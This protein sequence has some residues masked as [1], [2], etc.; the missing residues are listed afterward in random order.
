MTT[1]LSLLE[2]AIGYQFKD[3]NLLK[4]ALTHRSK[5]KN[6]NERFEFLGDALLETVISAQL[7]R[8]KP[9]ASEGDLTRLRATL[10]RG[11]TLSEI[12]DT[13]RIKD[14]MIVGSGELRTGG[15]QRE[16][17][18]ADA[19][20][21]IFAAIYLDS[22]FSTCEAVITQLFAEKMANLPEAEDLKDS[23]TKLQELAQSQAVEVPQYELLSIEGPDHA[24]LFTVRCSA[25][26]RESTAS[27]SSKKKAEQQ[28]ARKILQHLKPND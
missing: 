14:Y 11:R 19:L 22:N 6:N 21:A 7:F 18:V 9:K 25:F 10:V 8:Y 27:D 28:A 1:R 16:S 20:E 26:D 12:A 13:L 4:T 2:S 15:Y 17:T 3:Q 24:K 23:K 5:S